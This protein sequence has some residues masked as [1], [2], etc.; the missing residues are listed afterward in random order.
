MAAMNDQDKPPGAGSPRE[1]MEIAAGFQRSRVLLT[2]YELGVFTCLGNESKS[3]TEVAR[4]IGTDARATDRLMNALCAMGLL[5]KADNRFANT[6]LTSRFL[7]RGQPEYMSNLMH[8]VH[9]WDSWSTMTQAVKLGTSALGGRSRAHDEVWSQAFIAAMH[10]RASQ[11]APAIVALLDL[12]R[13]KRVLDV[14]GGS[15]AFAMAFA[16][17]K[18]D[19]HAVVFDLPQV[20]PLTTDYVRREGM[21]DRVD[22]LAGD[23]STDDFG[24][25]YDLVFLSAIIHSNSFEENR[26]L[27]RKCASALNRGGQLVVVDF[28]M[29]E[30]RTGPVGH[31]LF[32][33]N[34]LVGTKAGDTYIES[35]IR[36][37]MI[38]AG[39]EQVERKETG[40]GTSMMIGQAEP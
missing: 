8:T 2:A 11:H 14:G 32:A 3:S 6:P 30:D 13:V 39:L 31:A 34:M 21:S 1:I 9:L 18:T 16:R 40:F 23:Y 12:T 28:V 29:N 17:A 15:G 38:D 22:T 24:N 25:G 37:W 4:S 35:E 33:L 26:R 19:V 20:V 5:R 27:I 10:W 36:S 7:V